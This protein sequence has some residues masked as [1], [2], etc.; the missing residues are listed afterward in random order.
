MAVSFTNLGDLITKK[1]VELIE[2]EFPKAKVEPFDR[3]RGLQF[4]K[5]NHGTFC[6]E[7]TSSEYAR[8]ETHGVVSQER[9]YFN[10][11]IYLRYKDQEA[12][13]KTLKD[14]AEQLWTFLQHFNQLEIDNYWFNGEPVRITY[15]QKAKVAERKT[16]FLRAAQMEWMCWSQRT[17]GGV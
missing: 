11:W 10:I 7:Q 5:G 16:T 8:E 12:Q 3:V 14:L 6:V 17:R 4:P 1:L 13:D 15:G 2:G 9:F